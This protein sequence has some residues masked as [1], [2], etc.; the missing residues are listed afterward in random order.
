MNYFF[1]PALFFNQ[2]SFYVI[3]NFVI[4]LIPILSCNQTAKNQAKKKKKFSIVVLQ[5]SF[6]FFFFYPFEFILSN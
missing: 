6:S 2:Q 3:E 1:Q 4:F 5:A